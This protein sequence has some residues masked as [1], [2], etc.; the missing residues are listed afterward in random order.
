[1]RDLAGRPVKAGAR[2]QWE[3]PEPTVDQAA[4]LIET[5]QAIGTDDLFV[6]FGDRPNYRR[7]MELFA[8]AVTRVL[9]PVPV[10]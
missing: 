5:W 10:G 4:E 9:G 7:R 1:M 2:I 3:D 6:W 8:Q